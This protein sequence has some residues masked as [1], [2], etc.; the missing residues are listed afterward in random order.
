M[1]QSVTCSRRSARRTT[2]AKSPG[3]SGPSSRSSGSAASGRDPP[4]LSKRGRGCP[5]GHKPDSTTEVAGPGWHGIRAFARLDPLRLSRLS[6]AAAVL[7]LPHPGSTPPAAQSGQ[8]RPEW[9]CTCGPRDQP[10]A[11][12]PAPSDWRDTLKRWSKG[13][14]LSELPFSFPLALAGAGRRATGHLPP[15]RRDRPLNF[16]A[17]AWYGSSGAKQGGDP[18]PELTPDLLVKI[19]TRLGR[20]QPRFS[21]A[22]PSRLGAGTPSLQLIPVLAQDAPLRRRPRRLSVTRQRGANVVDGVVLLVHHDRALAKPGT[23]RGGRR[24]IQPAR[25]VALR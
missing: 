1:S 7:L 22:T 13:R 23:L 11:R 3:A 5:N 12:R 14:V 21:T 2:A 15:K 9:T 4:H 20:T 18:V 19:V 16:P 24:R 6:C 25:G 8:K 17:P 10:S